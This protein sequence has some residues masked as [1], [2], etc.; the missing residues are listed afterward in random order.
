MPIF[1]VTLVLCSSRFH[2][3]PSVPFHMLFHPTPFHESQHTH[4]I[5]PFPNPQ[6]GRREWKVRSKG[7]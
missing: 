7:L 3:S 2:G 6:F 4:G 1:G 5:V